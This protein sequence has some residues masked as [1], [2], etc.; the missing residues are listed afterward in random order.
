L[1]ITH[2]IN[3]AREEIRLKEPEHCQAELLDGVAYA[4]DYIGDSLARQ[5]SAFDLQQ[6]IHAT[7][8]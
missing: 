3:Q 1:L 5:S 6:F 7:G 2:A 8:G 4:R